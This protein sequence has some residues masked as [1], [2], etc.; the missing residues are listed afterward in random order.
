M[1]RKQASTSN[2]FTSAMPGGTS[3]FGGGHASL[4][5]A[6][7]HV[8]VLLEFMERFDL[9]RFLYDEDYRQRLNDILDRFTDDEFEDFE[10]VY[11][12]RFTMN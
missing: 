7:P 9:A 3:P 2:S 10:K 6:N 11:A 1:T 5:T 8:P 4:V 12:N